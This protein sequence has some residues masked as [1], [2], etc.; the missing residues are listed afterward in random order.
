MKINHR[1]LPDRQALKYFFLPFYV[2]TQINLSSAPV[3][4]EMAYRVD[5]KN[6]TSDSCFMMF[7]FV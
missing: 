3:N 5:A 4:S 1:C 7:I 6:C 2:T